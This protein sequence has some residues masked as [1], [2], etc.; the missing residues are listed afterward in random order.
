[1]KMRFWPV[2]AVKHRMIGRL[3]LQRQLRLDGVILLPPLVAMRINRKR[4]GGVP[5]VSPPPAAGA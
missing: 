3:V 5:P 2:S 1:M 4:N